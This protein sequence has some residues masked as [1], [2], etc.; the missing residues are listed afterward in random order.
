MWQFDALI[1]NLSP[2]LEEVCRVIKIDIGEVQH[3]INIL[4]KKF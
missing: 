2:E 1:S 3:P 4:I